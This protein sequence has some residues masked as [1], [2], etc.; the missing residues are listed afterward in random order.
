[1]TDQSRKE[2]ERRLEQARRMVAGATDRST[3]ER[4]TELVD[5]LAGKLCEAKSKAASG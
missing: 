3:T 2:L 1:M 4:L 5:E